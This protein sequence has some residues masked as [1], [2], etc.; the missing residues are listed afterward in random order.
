MRDAQP[1]L[2]ERF[3]CVYYWRLRCGKVGCGEEVLLRI[4]AASCGMVLEEHIRVAGNG[5]EAV[6]R[7]GVGRSGH[8]RWRKGE[9]WGSREEE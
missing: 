6:E 8:E 3:H 5:G 7:D 1:N 2:D 4:G 9:V